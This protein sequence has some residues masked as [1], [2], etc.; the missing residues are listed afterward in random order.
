MIFGGTSTRILDSSLRDCIIYRKITNKK[1]IEKL[2]K[3]LDILG[4][5]VVENGM[6]INTSKIKAIRFMSACVKIPL[7]YSLAD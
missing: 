6:K 3:V 5:L 4:E 7:S 2:P 1:Y